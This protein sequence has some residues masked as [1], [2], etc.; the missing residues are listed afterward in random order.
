[1]S[2]KSHFIYKPYIEG[3][4]ETS[5]PQDIFDRFTGFN[6][7]LCIDFPVLESFEVQGAYLFIK[8]KNT[9]H[10]PPMFKIHGD[11]V[12]R[13]EVDEDGLLIVL[14]GGHTITKKVI[15]KD[16]VGLL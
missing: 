3:Y 10:V 8:T 11:A 9:E 7:Y 14:K 5:E 6:A 15:E 2:T 1:M 13:A 12:I 4:E 16:F